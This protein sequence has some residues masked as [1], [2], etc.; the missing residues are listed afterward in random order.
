MPQMPQDFVSK[1][2]RVTAPEKPIYR[3]HFIDPCRLVRHQTP[4]DDDP[5]STRF[6]FEKGAAQASSGQ[7]WEDVARPGHF[8][9]EYKGK[10]RKS[11]HSKL[12]Y[13]R[14]VL[15]LLVIMGIAACGAPLID[16]KGTCGQ[17]TQQFLD[18]VHSLV[19]D[20]LTPVMEDG[21]RSGPTADVTKRLE[22]LDSRISELNTPECNPRTQAVRDALRLYML[23]TR[24]YFTTVA[25]RAVY[26]EGQV[27]AHLS[28][29]YEAGMAFERAF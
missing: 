26:G 10:L 20:E 3:E 12:R 22:Q 25:G 5:T 9:R 4:N 17:Q 13:L 19:I 28:K 14:F 6:G 2:R 15:P 16:Y 27:Q 1:W 8:G 18:Y 11:I 29:M 21:F 24:N 7:D 23:E